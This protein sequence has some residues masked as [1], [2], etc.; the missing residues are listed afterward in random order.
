MLLDLRQIGTIRTSFKTSEGVPIQPSNSDVIGHVEVNEEYVKGLRSL[1]MFSHIILLYWFHK[2][3][4]AK[5]EVKPYLDTKTHGL[6]STRAPA[7]PNPIGL[8]IVELVEINENVIKFRGADMLDETPLIDIKPYVPEFDNRPDAISGWLSTSTIRDGH[9][10]QAD[11][12]F[13]N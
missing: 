13:E 9:D 3:K 12:R 8:S 2:A 5:M 11:D 6:F 4:P 1:D 7:R 10:Y